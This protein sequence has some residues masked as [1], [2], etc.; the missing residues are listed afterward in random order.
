MS[1]TL[2]K[3]ANAIVK[4]LGIDELMRPKHRVFRREQLVIT[5]SAE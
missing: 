3:E 4:Q 2:L 5:L 1:D